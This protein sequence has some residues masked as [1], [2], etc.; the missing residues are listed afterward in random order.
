MRIKGEETLDGELIKT[1]EQFIEDLCNRINV[2]HNTMM[3]EEN[4]ELQ[5][6]YLIGFLKVFAGRLNRVCE[7]K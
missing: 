4:K 3:D 5:L 1:P 2:L 7:R 6:A